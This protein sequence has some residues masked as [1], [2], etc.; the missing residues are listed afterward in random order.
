ML[1]LAVICKIIVD[2]IQTEFSVAMTTILATSL[3]TFNFNLGTIQTLILNSL[4]SVN[5]IIRIVVV[6]YAEGYNKVELINEN[7]SNTN[8]RK[9]FA[10]ASFVIM[11]I[12]VFLLSV[13]VI[14]KSEREKRRF[15]IS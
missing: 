15:F 11:V 8:L 10:I 6:Y 12:Y 13:Y 3:L 5:F 1:M 4:N 14:Y 2:W 7:E 9:F